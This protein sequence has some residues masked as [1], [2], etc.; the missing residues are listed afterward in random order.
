VNQ[1]IVQVEAHGD[2]PNDLL[3]RR[4]LLVEHLGRLVNLTT[5]NRDPD[6]FTVH[7]DGHVLV[8]GAAHRSF[9]ISP[10][11]GA[12]GGLPG[13]SDVRWGDTGEQAVIT[14]GKLGALVGLRD[15]DLRAEL[16][17]FNT[18]TL[19]FTDRVTEVHRSG[20][21]ANGVGGLDFFVQEPYVVSAQGDYDA[22]GDGAMDRTYLQRI[23]GINPL[24]GSMLTGLEGVITLSG[25]NGNIE[26]PYRPTDSTD[27]IIERINDAP[28]E[29][30]AYLDQN[31]RLVL[32]ATA[33]ADSDNP[34][35][36]I[37]HVEDTGYFLTA[38]A[39]LLAA[40]GAGGGL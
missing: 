32:K 38:F 40:P 7:I 19:G 30:K 13:F 35:F 17:S 3:D 21:G 27:R 14:G 31:N 25:R 1:Q 9:S 11:E 6:E 12:V 29:V 5:D 28:G 34:D 10:M 8:Q 4:D 37:R 36:V 39:G 26:V 20:M 22:D 16:Q 18:M 15:D 2:K 23:G 33:A 24:E